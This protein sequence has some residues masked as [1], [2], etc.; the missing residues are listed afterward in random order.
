MYRFATV[1]AIVFAM[2]SCGDAFGDLTSGDQYTQFADV[3]DSSTGE[4][5][6]LAD[7][8]VLDSTQS[9]SQAPY[10]FD[11][12]LNGLDSSTV[13]GS[14]TILSQHDIVVH[15]DACPDTAIEDA[16]DQLAC[17][18][19]GTDCPVKST[20]VEDDDGKRHCIEIDQCSE[21]GAIDV[22]ELIESLLTG[23]KVHVKVLAEVWIGKPACSMMPCPE[24][25]P[26]CNACWAPLLIGGQELPILLLG[27]GMSIGCQGTSCDFD[28]ECSPMQPGASYWVWG[29]ASLLGGAAQLSVDGYCL[30]TKD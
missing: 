17:E 1:L 18:D 5:A 20:C 16:V 6:I 28:E 7:A 15:H 26:C 19:G 21:D 22:A 12:I 29:N 13:V 27:N 24:S 25:N 10:D 4:L 23:K 8:V 3:I 14:D 30:A 2:T 9:D 11:S